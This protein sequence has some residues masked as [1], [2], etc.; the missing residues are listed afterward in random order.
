MHHRRQA[1]R[2]I[3]ICNLKYAST[4]IHPAPDALSRLAASIGGVRARFQRA[5]TRLVLHN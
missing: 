3:F 4:I 5:I 2:D 1:L